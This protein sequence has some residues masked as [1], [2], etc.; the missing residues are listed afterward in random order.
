MSLGKSIV[1]FCLAQSIFSVFLKQN[2]FKP[3]VTDIAVLVHMQKK[4]GKQ[5]NER[6][7]HKVI[8]YQIPS[9]TTISDATKS[10]TV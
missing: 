3:N 7:G 1:I 8:G 4:L 10:S 5:L 6:Y 2:M 9:I